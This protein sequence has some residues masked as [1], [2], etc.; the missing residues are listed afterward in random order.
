MIITHMRSSLLGA[1]DFCGHKMFLSYNLNLKE[2]ANFK[3]DAGNGLHKAL[4]LL[5]LCKFAEQNKKKTIENEIFDK[6]V[7]ISSITPDKAFELGWAHYKKLSPDFPDWDDE[8]TIKKYKKMYDALL[9]YKSGAYNPLNLDIVQPEQFFEFEVKEPWA[10]YEYVINGEVLSGYLKLRGT[11][12]LII[13]NEYDGFSA[14]DWKTGRRVNWGIGE[15]FNP[16]VKEYSDLKKDKQLLLYYYSLVKLLGTYNISSI[17]YYLQ[18][19]G[20]YEFHFDEQTYISAE[21]MIKE[22]FERI[23]SIKV[24]KLTKNTGNPAENYYNKRK[25][26]WCDFNKIWPKVST[27]QTVCEHFRTEIVQLGMDKVLD[28]HLDVSKLSDYTGGGRQNKDKEKE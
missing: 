8:K 27:K 17:I 2:K 4:E 23:N 25:C 6:P 15:W 16:K 24:P 5:G 3:A 14:L 11:V 19:G 26:G 21:K 22:S 18:D 1:E 12:D 28:K 9:S 7:K 20:P 13:R 10:K